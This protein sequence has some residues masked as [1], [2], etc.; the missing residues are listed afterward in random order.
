[1]REIA[2]NSASSIS[3]IPAAVKNAKTKDSAA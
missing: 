1:M 2:K 3:Q